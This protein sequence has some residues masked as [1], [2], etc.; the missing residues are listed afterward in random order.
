MRQTGPVVLSPR[1]VAGDVGVSWRVLLAAPAVAVATT[2]VA[3]LAANSAGIPFR[4]PDHVAAGY[5]L[6]VG[7]G[8][9]VLIYLDILIRA[10]WRGRLPLPERALLGDVWRTRWRGQRLAGVAVGVVSFYA[11]YLAYRN[12]KGAL[13]LLR[14]GDIF[15]TQLARVDQAIFLGNKPQDL[16]HSLLGTGIS[17]QILSG[18]YAAFI[19][20]LPLSLGLYLVFSERLSESLLFATALSVNWVLGLA[21]YYL[22]PSLGPAFTDPVAFSH[23]PHSE[24]TNLQQMLWDQRVAF[25]HRPATGPLQ[26]IAGFASLH[27]AMSFTALLG[28]YL[29]DL[30]RRVKNWLWTWLILVAISTVYFGWHFFVDDLAGL[31]IGAGALG[32]ACLLTGRTPAAIRRRP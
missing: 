32:I 11:T 16:L 10:G 22:V 23:L 8:I 28:A 9:G 21:S 30:P 29:L 17:T 13:P 19:V 7:A 24:V 4:D 31:A 5:V 14:P 1:A 12:L 15:D 26:A 27:V 2:I 6:E 25:L 18:I 20:F 3:L